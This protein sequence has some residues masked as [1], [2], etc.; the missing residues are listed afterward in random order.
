[1]K[2]TVA[3]NGEK[4]EWKEKKMKKES[5]DDDEKQNQKNQDGIRINQVMK[6]KYMIK[7]RTKNI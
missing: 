4:R 1:M 5:I 6:R 3:E 7:I 2:K